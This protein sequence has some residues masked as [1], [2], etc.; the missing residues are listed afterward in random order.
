[1]LLGDN[2]SGKSNMFSVRSLRAVHLVDW[3]V[4]CVENQIKLNIQTGSNYKR[5]III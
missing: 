5:L 1:M 3:S 4:S 2:R